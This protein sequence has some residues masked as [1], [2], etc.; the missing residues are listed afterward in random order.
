M[1]TMTK[2]SLLM[3]IRGNNEAG[4][5]LTAQFVSGRDYKGIDLF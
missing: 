4:S 5:S 2:R 3:F 1:E